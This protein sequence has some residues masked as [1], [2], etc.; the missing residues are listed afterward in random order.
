M[1][2]GYGR[3]TAPPFNPID[4]LRSIFTGTL[5]AVGGFSKATGEAAVGAG[6]ADLVEIGRPLISNPDLVERFRHDAPLNSP[7]VRK[8]YGEDDHGFT[9]YPTLG[10]EKRPVNAQ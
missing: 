8:F 5:L 3:R 7:D 1:G 9:D 10:E 4:I 6:H 2:R